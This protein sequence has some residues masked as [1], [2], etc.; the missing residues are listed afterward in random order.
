M[1]PSA[2]TTCEAGIVVPFSRSTTANRLAGRGHQPHRAS[3]RARVLE[4]HPGPGAVRAGLLHHPGQVLAVERAGRE[5]IRAQLVPGRDRPAHEVARV[6]GKGA[7]LPG[8]H[9][10]AVRGSWS[11]RRARGP[12]LGRGFDHDHAQ[13]GA[14][15]A[16]KQ[17]AREQAAA[18]R[19]RR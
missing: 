4:P 19:H 18:R 11:S 12:T 8:G 17:L 6:A 10:E 5:V 3:A 1:F 7:H 2:S 13:P 15:V 9:V 14:M 16:A